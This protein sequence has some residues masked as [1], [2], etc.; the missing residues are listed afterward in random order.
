M[1]RARAMQTSAAL[2][3]LSRSLPDA[4]S[5]EARTRHADAQHH[6]ELDR[7]DLG[8]QRDLAGLRRPRAPRCLSAGLRD[9]HPGRAFPDRS[10][11]CSRSSSADLPSSFASAIPPTSPSGT[12]RSAGD[13]QSRP[14]R[15]G[16]WS[17]PS[18]RAFASTAGNSPAGPPGDPHLHRVVVL[19][20]P[21]EGAV[22][23]RL[24]L[25]HWLPGTRDLSAAGRR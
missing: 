3:R 21:R 18:S 5:A 20:V 23:R 2:P 19:G 22:R 15:R 17:A 16:W 4:L 12:A 13:R 25:S 8:R 11:C 7:A 1:T 14:L 6:H 10:D 24:P 9:H